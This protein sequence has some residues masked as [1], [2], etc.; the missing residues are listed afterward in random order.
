ME[1]RE[2]IKVEITMKV[3]VEKA[4]ECFTDPQHITKW[5][6]ASSDWK[7]PEASN[8]LRPGGKFNYRMEAHDGSVGFNFKGRYLVVEEHESIVYRIEDE[9]MVNIEFVQTGDETRVSETFDP[10]NVHPS[11]AQRDGWQAILNNFKN[12][13]ESI[14]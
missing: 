5:N 9:R 7:C 12:Y 4:W 2:K 6:F 10:E 11:E 14:A 8:D 13:A 1:T 3:P